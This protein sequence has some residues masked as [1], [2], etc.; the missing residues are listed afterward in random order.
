MTSVVTASPGDGAARGGDPLGV[1]LG[2]VLPAH[3]REDR[4][5]PAL[6]WDVQVLAH[7]LGASEGR[8][9]AVGEVGGLDARQA[10]T[11]HAR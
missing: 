6:Q 10:Q 4:V 3:R 9:E 11:V 5:A 8:E 7:R 1:L 2:G